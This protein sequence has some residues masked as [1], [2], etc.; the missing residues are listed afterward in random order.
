MT[1]DETER[2][3]L[4]IPGVREYRETHNDLRRTIGFQVYL[5]DGRI[6]ADA[7]ESNGDPNHRV[8]LRN[9]A[10]SEVR[11]IVQGPPAGEVIGNGTIQKLAT[12]VDGKPGEPAL[13]WSPPRT[14]LGDLRAQLLAAID[15]LEGAQRKAAILTL[16]AYLSAFTTDLMAAIHD[17]EPPGAVLNEQ[18]DW[19][20][21]A[22]GG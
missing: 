21:Q 16:R 14:A 7:L 20:D 15:D 6:I 3:I 5:A 8:K 2:A 10:L 1:R 18:L 13:A 9:Y 19:L 12:T 11:R 4:A 17:R 22:I